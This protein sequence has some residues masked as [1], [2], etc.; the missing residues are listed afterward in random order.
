M[1]ASVDHQD[2]VARR[3]YEC[4]S[5]LKGILLGHPQTASSRQRFERRPPGPRPHY[6]A[7]SSPLP[8][9]SP[10]RRPC[11]IDE[12]GKGDLHALCSFTSLMGRAHPYRHHRTARSLNLFCVV[13]QLREMLTAERSAVMAQPRHD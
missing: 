10:I 8:R 11:A 2:F 9:C 5:Q 3:E 6:V 1:P 12:K 7:G 13:A 4:S